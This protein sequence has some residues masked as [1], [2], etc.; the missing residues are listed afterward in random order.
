MGIRRH[1][2]RERRDCCLHLMS[3][4]QNPIFTTKISILSQNSS[5]EAHPASAEAKFQASSFSSPLESCATPPHVRIA[6]LFTS[7]QFHRETRSL[8]NQTPQNPSSDLPFEPGSP[9]GARRLHRM[10]FMQTRCTARSRSA[11]Q[12]RELSDGNTSK[13]GKVDVSAPRSKQTPTDKDAPLPVISSQL[14]LSPHHPFPVSS[15][16][17]ARICSFKVEF[18]PS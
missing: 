2:S 11:S 15:L 5:T 10:T 18:S 9:R 1:V 6:S 17:F 14:A 16:S 7:L 13:E 3:I 12:N 4:S 8:T